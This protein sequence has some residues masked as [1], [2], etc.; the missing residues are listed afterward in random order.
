M[1][2][3]SSILAW[4][5]PWTEEPVGYSPWGCKG[6]GHNWAIDH[7]HHWKG[8]VFRNFLIICF[9]AWELFTVFP[10]R[11]VTAPSY[12]YTPISVLASFISHNCLAHSFHWFWPE[13]SS[14]PSY[15]CPST[16]GCCKPK[17]GTRARIQ[18]EPNQKKCIWI[19]VKGERIWNRR[20]GRILDKHLSSDLETYALMS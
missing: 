10:A 12:G 19:W 11:T 15:P 13:P 18:F 14:F 2:T 6:V 5:I 9:T 16:S 8:R 3:H 7:T 20:K 4:K 1:A 17:F